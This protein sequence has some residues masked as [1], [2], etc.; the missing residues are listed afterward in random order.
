MM[1]GERCRLAY[2]FSMI[3]LPRASFPVREA[4]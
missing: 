4:G 1:S 3:I 2:R